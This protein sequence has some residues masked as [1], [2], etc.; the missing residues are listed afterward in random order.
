MASGSLLSCYLARLT[1]PEG[2][3]FTREELRLEEQERIDTLARQLKADIRR[4]P[5]KGAGRYQAGGSACRGRSLL[6]QLRQP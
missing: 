4:L 2:A 5:A 1:I 3:V 6:P